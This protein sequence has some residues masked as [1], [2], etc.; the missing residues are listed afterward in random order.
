MRG[1]Y[2]RFRKLE[3]EISSRL[4]MGESIDEIGQDV[5]D[6]YIGSVKQIERKNEYDFSEDMVKRYKYLRELSEIRN[7]IFWNQRDGQ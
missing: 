1:N 2:E 5:A 3:T 4:F 7:N 6:Q